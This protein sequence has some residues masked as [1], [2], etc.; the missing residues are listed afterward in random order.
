MIYK[1]P[2]NEKD[3]FNSMLNSLQEAG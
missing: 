1:H 3:R 2:V